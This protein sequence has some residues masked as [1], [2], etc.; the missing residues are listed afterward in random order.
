MVGSATQAMSVET[1]MS[2]YYGLFFLSIGS[3]LPFAALW[4]DTLNLS[5]SFSGAIFAAP[6]ISIVLFTILIGGWAD[7]LHDWRTAIIACNWIVF[8]LYSWFVF[9][10]G[11]WD[12]LIVW[13]LAGLFSHASSPIMDAAALNLTKKRGSDFARIRAI[14]SIGFIV[15]V[16]LAGALYERVGYQWFVP[17]LLLGVVARVLA[18]NALPHFRAP[19]V[20][21]MEDSAPSVANNSK[22]ELSHQPSVQHVK[23]KHSG[24][25]LLNHRGILLVIAG[26]ALLNASHSFNNIFAVLHWTHTGISTSMASVLW[27]VGVI[28]EVALMWGF[29]RVAKKFSARKCLIFASVVCIVR[30][31]LTGSEPSLVQLFFLQSLHAITFGLSFLACVNF[32]ARR[33]HEDNAAQAQRVSVTMATFFMALAAWL[34]G[35]LY[36]Q[37]AGQSYWAMAVMA[38]LGGICVLLS[39]AS[40]LED[41][42]S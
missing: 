12:V 34:S 38:L 39:Y 7:R 31:L 1:R 3:A 18:A 36:E 20:P 35:W 26:A 13:A 16:L 21:A 25:G 19:T 24:L 9:R 27:S 8:A 29:S 23:T 30:W 10:T 42:A 11:S 5:P 17:V 15:G 32:I 41:P 6:A 14:G 37:F 40:D 28:A 4:F 2:S 33:V 22:S